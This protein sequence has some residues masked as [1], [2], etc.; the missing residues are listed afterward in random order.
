MLTKEEIPKWDADYFISKM[1][2]V[3]RLFKNRLNVAIKLA[4]IK[5]DSTVLDIGCNRAYL[6][7]LIHEQNSLC[8]LYGIDIDL[9]PLEVMWDTHCEFKTGDVRT[10]PYQ[11]ES[12]DIVFVTD[13]LEHVDELDIALK[14]IHRVIKPNGVA[15]LSGPT[16]SRF[17]KFCR[18]LWLRHF[19]VEYHV[20]TVRNIE[21]KLESN[22]FQLIKRR[23]L[24]RFPIPELFRISKYKKI[25]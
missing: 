1:P 9:P 14:E 13:V 19:N 21:K 15:I 7:K 4:E 17:Y 23:S 25:V 22:R 5:D 20:H 18:F 16:E 8:K 11:N 6:F 3:T 12:F 24:P 2:F 10:I